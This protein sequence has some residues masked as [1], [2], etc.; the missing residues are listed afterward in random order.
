M[1]PDAAS[2]LE[3]PAGFGEHGIRGP[4]L[5][6]AL[7][8]EHR[9]ELF[10]TEEQLRRLFNPAVELRPL[11]RLDD[12]YHADHTRSSALFSERGGGRRD[13]RARYNLTFR[14]IAQCIA[15]GSAVHYHRA[16]EAGR[17]PPPNTHWKYWKQARLP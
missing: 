8:A 15:D 14:A 6:R 3:R 7:V 2:D 17:L 10:G 5:L 13:H 11:L 9:D 4:G 16:V 1:G 12:W